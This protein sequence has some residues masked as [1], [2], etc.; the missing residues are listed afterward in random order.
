MNYSCFS[1]GCV[2][3]I[4]WNGGGDLILSGS[5]DKRLVLTR[6]VDKKVNSSTLDF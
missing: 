6:Y 2:N 3:T 1:V 5:D 4:Q